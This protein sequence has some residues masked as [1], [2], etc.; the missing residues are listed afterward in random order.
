MTRART[1]MSLVRSALAPALAVLIV[2]NFAGYALLG[3]NGLLAWG[4]YKRQLKERRAELAVLQA[5][6]AQ[7]TRRNALV[8]PRGVDP[9]MADE[10]VRKQLG[11]VRPDEVIIDTP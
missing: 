5:E 7:I 8:D 9:D 4:D 2:A 1:A 11:L 10:M 3:S 6:R